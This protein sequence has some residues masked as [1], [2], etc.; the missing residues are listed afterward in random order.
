VNSIQL[1]PFQ[2]GLDKAPETPAG[3]ER[4]HPKKLEKKV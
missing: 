1:I 3:T 4:K 2:E